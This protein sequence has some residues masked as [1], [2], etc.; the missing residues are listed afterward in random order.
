MKSNPENTPYIPLFFIIQGF[1]TFPNREISTRVDSTI[2][3]G[4]Y[5]LGA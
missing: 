5:I 2:S 1:N 4:S 3:R